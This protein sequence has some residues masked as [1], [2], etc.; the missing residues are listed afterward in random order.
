MDGRAVLP[1][2]E[3]VAA[4]IA[5]AVDEPTMRTR[6]AMVTLALADPSAR[7]F[8][9]P[10]VMS[11]AL[12]EWQAQRLV[13]DDAR[14]AQLALALADKEI[15]GHVVTWTI[16]EWVDDAHTF[17]MA[18]VRQTP[19][20]FVAEPASLLA[21]TAMV[22]GDCVLAEAALNVAE[23]ASPGHALAR[24]VR[25]MHEM[26]LSPSQVRSALEEITAS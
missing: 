10:Q 24:S 11:D 12:R 5:P 20:P 25:A 22:K 21:L 4:S 6:A 26:N 18:L 17:W 13:L 16:R 9:T 7:R 23:A 15:R 14:V 2:R 3:A 8:V 1:S 19:A